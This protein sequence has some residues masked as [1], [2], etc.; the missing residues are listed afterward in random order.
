MLQ[1]TKR[2]DNLDLM[3]TIAILAVITLHTGL[4]EFSFGNK[5]FLLTDIVQYSF[6]IL[7]Q[8]VPIFLMVN[9]FLLFRKKDLVIK[10]HY[11]KTLKLF[12]LFLFWTGFLYLLSEISHGNI[13]SVS[14]SG[15][16]KAIITAN[17]SNAVT[18]YLQN[19]I[20]VYLVF[21]M[22][23][24]IYDKEAS[25]FR[26]LFIIVLFFTAGLSIINLLAE[27]SNVFISNNV[28]DKIILFENFLKRF[29]PVGNGWF[30]LFFMLG[31]SILLNYD[32]VKK[33]RV[34][35]FFG[36]IVGVVAAVAFALVM[37]YKQRYI[38]NVNFVYSS[39]LMPVIL[40]G[41]WMVA[42]GYSS[43]DFLINKIIT[44]IGKNTLGIYLTH[45]IFIYLLRCFF[46][47]EMFW[48]RLLFYL[49]VLVCS[50]FF[51][52]FLRIIPGIRY[53][54]TV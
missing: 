22:L 24:L 3:K 5:G 32:N 34:I 53:F 6:R 35:Y 46:V 48:Q 4:W 31:G 36:G 20:A 51:S 18:W 23:K 2:L 14:I 8:G 26:I 38:Y 7:S 47:P 19:L 12:F 39:F 1:N 15:I 50:Y 9:G 52:L 42:E 45:W 33:R 44:S 21:P 41:L 17:S 54:V 43:K 10:K 28:F 40:V 11:L 25:L 30:L 27:F 49:I 37:S 29:S 13:S 16:V